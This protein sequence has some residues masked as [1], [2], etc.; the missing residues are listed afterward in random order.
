VAGEGTTGIPGRYVIVA[1]PNG[2]YEM[3]LIKVGPT[4]LRVVQVV[5]GLK[6]GDKVVMLGAIMINKPPVPPKLQ[7]AAEMK[8]GAPATREAAKP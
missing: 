4:D 2:S 3:R 6:E 7:I 8:R 1:L 5:D